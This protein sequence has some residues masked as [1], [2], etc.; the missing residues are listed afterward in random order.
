MTW[1]Q[2]FETIK[3]LSDASL[4]MRSPGDWYVSQPYVEIKRGIGLD[5]RYGN[6]STPEQAVQDHWRV[7]T[8]LAAD[9]VI[10]LHASTPNE[11]EHFLWNGHRWKKVPKE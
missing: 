6:G 8:T 3:A 1:E 5:G 4:K 11:R 10:V 2:M 9:E 7:L